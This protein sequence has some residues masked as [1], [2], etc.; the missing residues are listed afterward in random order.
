METIHHL[1]NGFSIAATPGNLFYCFIG[2]LWGTV[3]GILP[4]LGPLGGIAILL[5]LTFKL[6]AVA[7]IILLT[8]IFYGAMYGGSTTSILLNIP[9]EAASVITCIEGHQMALRGRAG[10]ALVVAALGSFIGGSLSVVGLMLFAPPLARQMVKVGPAEEFSV[11]L[12]AIVL[13]SYLSGKSKAKTVVMIAL[14]LLIA[15]VGQDPFTAYPRFTFGIQDF[16][17]GI[18]FV[19]LAIGL[20]GVSEILINLE[21]VADVKVIKPSLA[22]LFPRWKD[23]RDSSGPIWRGSIIGFIMGM[24]PG[25]SHVV[26]T[27]ISYIV[28][29]KLAKNPEEF[30]QGRIEGVAGP[31]TANNATTGSAMIPLLIL[32]VPAI[33]ATALLISGLLIHGVMPG[34]RLIADNPEVFWGLIA[35]MYIGN[36]MLTILNLPFVPLF[37]N[38]LRL[39]YAYLAPTILVICVIGVY[40]IKSSVL[41]IYILSVAGLGG[42]ILR[43]FDFD[44]A[45]LIMAI[46]LGD[47][48]EINFRRALTISEGKMEIFWANAFCKVLLAMSLCIILLQVFRGF[49]ELGEKQVHSGK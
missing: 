8:G 46:V 38:I 3:V 10:P 39:R 41:D 42:Y 6:D 35:S 40:T 48:L 19:S 28:E 43:K 20:F 4:G 44:L 24:I 49:K 36:L 2:V 23:L 15:S 47:K 18:N 29:K 45:P 13:L 17:E 1:W 26:S 21:A 11:I 31:E 14:G 16:A 27:S 12:L 34:P 9:G 32:G 25:I 30:G 7:A 37:V 33:P 22:S 5:P